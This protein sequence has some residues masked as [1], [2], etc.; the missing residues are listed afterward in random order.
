MKK[1]ENIVCHSIIATALFILLSPSSSLADNLVISGDQITTIDSDYTQVGDILIQDSGTLIV[2]NG[3]TLTANGYS[4]TLKGKGTLKIENGVLKANKLSLYD[5]SKLDMAQ[6]SNLELDNFLSKNQ[7]N[8]K[9]KNSK[10]STSS[11]SSTGSEISISSGEITSSSAVSLNVQSFSIYNSTI[12]GAPIS[13]ESPSTVSI[14]GSVLDGISYISCPSL[15]VSNSNIRGTSLKINCVSEISVL[16]SIISG[17]SSITANDFSIS[18]N[19]K[20]EATSLNIEASKITTTNSNISGVSAIKAG[21]FSV[22]DYSKIE[23]TSL[24]IEASTISIKNSN[25]TG[26][27]SIKADDFSISNGSK[28]LGRSSLD[29]NSSKI[30]ISYSEISNDNG[31]RGTSNDDYGGIGGYSYLSIGSEADLFIYNSKIS[32]G[33]GGRGEAGLN[34]GNGGHSFLSISSESNLFIYISEI[35]TGNGGDGGYGPYMRAGDPNGR[36]FGGEGGD[37]GYSSLSL[38]SKSNLSITNSKIN[39][40]KGG[41]GGL[42]LCKGGNGGYSSV[43]IASK[44]NLSIT[45]SEIKDGNGGG[46]G[47]GHCAGDTN[48]DYGT[49]YFSI[50]SEADLSITNSEIS[51]SYDGYGSGRSNSFA[52]INFQQLY[53]IDTIFNRP[54]EVIKNNRKAYFTNTILPSINVADNAI[55]YKY[56]YIISDVT[57]KLGHPVNNAKVDV[58]YYLNETTYKSGTTDLNGTAKIP[59]LS[60]II[61]S[62]G[63]QFLGNYKIVAYYQNHITSKKGVEMKSN[64]NVALNFSDLVVEPVSVLRTTDNITESIELLTLISGAQA[65]IKKAN[66][67]FADT[68]EAEKLLQQAQEFKEKNELPYA[69]EN[70]FR[71]KKSAEEAKN[72]RMIEYFGG[73]II[74]IIALILYKYKNKQ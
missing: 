65:S 57:D 61:T 32:S 74:L 16:K 50:T 34:G 72:I 33:S 24:N 28:I 29:I 53:V 8:I 38:A 45:N 59:V 60:N 30:Y 11:F 47:G 42:G 41:Y 49:S 68:S 3:A 26:V 66:Q 69:V 1:S 6:N 9:I 27:S 19:S 46:G 55:A 10:I 64:Q 58:L 43:S 35:S 44:S 63:D 56:L 21:D 25:I 36:L 37:G 52:S 14:E 5:D 67:I 18:D 15:Y 20:I 2:K 51:K 31:G 17:V 4:L 39:S 12:K 62:Q 70:A 40:G 71:A 73:F 22:S 23:A 7:T 48:G 13:V 54:F